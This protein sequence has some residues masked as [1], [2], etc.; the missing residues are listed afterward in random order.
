MHRRA[1]KMRAH[2][3][4]CQEHA[5][6]MRRLVMSRGRCALPLGAAA[7]PGS[8]FGFRQGCFQ[9]R[10]ASGTSAEVSAGEDA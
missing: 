9:L 5:W 3:G 10:R 6:S 1:H 2:S 8:C 7:A 4:M